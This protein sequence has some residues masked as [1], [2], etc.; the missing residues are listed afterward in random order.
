MLKQSENNSILSIVQDMSSKNLDQIK[1]Y[2]LL[3][4]TDTKYVLNTSQAE[5]LFKKISNHYFVLEVNS[6]K[7]QNYESYYFDTEKLEFYHKH[8]NKKNN[9]SKVRFR[10]YIGSDLIFLETKTKSKGRTRKYR[11]VF[12][13]I[14]SELNDEHYQF[15]RKNT[16]IETKLIK[17]QQNT[18]SR[19]TLLGKRKK[20][21]ITIDYDI[22]F[23]RLLDD[24]ENKEDLSGI[25][26][27][28]A[29][30]EF[31]NLLE[32]KNKK[33]IIKYTLGLYEKSKL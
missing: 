16:G 21:R 20:E 24:T 14:S 3:N 13:D 6:N 8:H 33:E 1:D 19:I 15:I 9:R 26:I 27:P 17:S 29:I 12:N 23:N 2:S 31:V 5:M 4:R 7:V 28:Q 30:E 32:I 18:F 11:K 25:D 22:N 10:K